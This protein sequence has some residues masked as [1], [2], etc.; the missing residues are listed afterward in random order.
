MSALF[1]TRLLLPW[2]HNRL[3]SIRPVSDA[4][5]AFALAGTIRVSADNDELPV[6]YIVG[7][8]IP[9]LTDTKEHLRP[10]ILQSRSQV[11]QDIAERVAVPGILNKRVS[12]EW[13]RDPMGT[14]RSGPIYERVYFVYLAVIAE[15]QYFQ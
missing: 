11:S 9:R 6:W 13:H 15:L 1:P 8:R 7:K 10:L 14:H 12:S 4:L 3:K 2:C 5:L